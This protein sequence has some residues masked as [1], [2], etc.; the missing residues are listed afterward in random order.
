M[1][2]TYSPSQTALW[3]ECPALRQIRKDGFLP[4]IIQH[5]EL[6]ALLGTAIAA[7]A[8]EY[9]RWMIGHHAHANEEIPPASVVA[10][11][12]ARAGET[13]NAGY[14]TLAEQGRR[15]PDW[16]RPYA[17]RV[18]ERATDATSAYIG[19]RPL[20]PDWRPVAAEHVLASGARMD[21]GVETS[22]GPMVLDLKTKLTLNDRIRAK[23]IDEYEVSPQLQ[24]YAWEWEAELGRPVMHAGILLYTLEPR[25][26]VEYVPVP[27]TPQG[28]AT[29]LQSARVAWADMVAEDSGERLA[30]QRRESCNNGF[31]RCPFFRFCHE[32]FE[33]ETTAVNS[34]EYTKIPG[35]GA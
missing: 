26:T 29:W 8:E 19:L 9:H 33:D 25:P 7:G 24:H 27:V 21:L 17:D 32:F 11:A 13:V 34:G 1:T 15:V 3:S 18:W 28:R 30:R 5:V 12:V 35:A 23:V 4:T 31:G 10:G 6:A 22:L 20:L 16:D 14:A 2:P